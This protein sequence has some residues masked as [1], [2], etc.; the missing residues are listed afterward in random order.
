MSYLAQSGSN[1]TI[2][3]RGTTRRASRGALREV[4]LSE[5]LFFLNDVYVVHSQVITIASGILGFEPF[6]KFHLGLSKH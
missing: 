2:G 1:I 3:K 4:S 5:L 6:H